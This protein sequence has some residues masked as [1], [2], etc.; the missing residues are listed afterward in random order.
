MI[1]D[2]KVVLHHTSSSLYAEKIRLMLD[3]SAIDW[4]S[5]QATTNTVNRKV[6]EVLVEGYSRRI[7]ILQ[8]GA[9][10]YCDASKITEKVAEL[11]DKEALD[12]DKVGEDIKV[13]FERNETEMVLA[14]I[15][16]FKMSEILKGYYKN[17]PL[18]QVFNWVKGRVN[19]V[20]TADK[21]PQI[22]DREKSIIQKKK[23]FTELN[24]MLVKSKFLFSNDIPTIADFGAYAI[25]WYELRMDMIKAFDQ[26]PDLGRWYEA[27]KVYR[28]NRSSEINPEDAFVIAYK[29]QPLEV[30]EEM[31]MSE[32]I[33]QT[34]DL[35]P[36]DYGRGVTPPVTG[37]LVG[38]SDTKYIVRRETKETGVIHVH[39][40]KQALGACM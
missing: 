6:Q 21:K 13:F 9:D 28:V 18:G 31:K 11:A 1:S 37:V 34:I 3:Y 39:F 30:P 24:K 22:P 38:E 16:A 8:V 5:V 10:I 12:K 26:W 27:M 32:R 2:N 20:R 19:A 29:N 25:I 17:I 23:Y 36:N 40:P 33:G 15:G 35:R 4:L 7:P 14:E